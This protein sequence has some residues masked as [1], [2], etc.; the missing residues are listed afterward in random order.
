M[1]VTTFPASQIRR[2]AF[3][4][5]I[6]VPVFPV[7]EAQRDWLRMVGALSAST[8]ALAAQVI[9]HRAPVAIPEGV[10]DDPPLLQQQRD[11]TIGGA[12][13]PALECPITLTSG[14]RPRR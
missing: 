7:G 12:V 9:E 13:G 4:R 6:V 11:G 5:S 8:R 3:N 14:E 1:F 2:A 10:D